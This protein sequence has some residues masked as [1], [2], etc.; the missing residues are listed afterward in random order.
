MPLTVQCPNLAS[1]VTD[2]YHHIWNKEWGSRAAS[3]TINSGLQ[4]TVTPEHAYNASITMSAAQASSGSSREHPARRKSSERIGR[5]QLINVLPSSKK[6][7]VYLTHSH[8]SWVE[9]YSW[10]CDSSALLT[11]SARCT[12]SPGTSKGAFREM[13]R[14][15]ERSLW[16]VQ[17]CINMQRGWRVRPSKFALLMT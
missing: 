9:S 10:G 8:L 3:A 14:L 4:G 15:G 16:C 11:R 2:C 5:T 12:A 13:Q 6:A 7:G 1:S 17:S